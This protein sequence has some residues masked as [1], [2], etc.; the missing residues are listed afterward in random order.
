M[1]ETEKAG[2]TKLH[3]INDESLTQKSGILPFLVSIYNLHWN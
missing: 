3:W 2:N 1:N